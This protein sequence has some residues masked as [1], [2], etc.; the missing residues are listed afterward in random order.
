MKAFAYLIIRFVKVYKKIVK[1]MNDIKIIRNF[2][3]EL[4]R[5]LLYL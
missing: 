2:S 1:G 4:L 5:V 3:L